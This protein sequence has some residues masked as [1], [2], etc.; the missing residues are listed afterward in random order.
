MRKKERWKEEGR[1]GGVANKE[2]RKGEGKED[3]SGRK[4]VR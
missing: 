4:G 2:G 1:K 3:E